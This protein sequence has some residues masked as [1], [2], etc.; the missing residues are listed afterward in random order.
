MKEDSAL[1]GDH[2]ARHRTFAEHG[3]GRAFPEMIGTA[4]V[5][6][7]AQDFEA[8]AGRA[9]RL[10]AWRFPMVGGLKRVGAKASPI[11]LVLLT[12]IMDRNPD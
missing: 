3:L 9:G 2:P 1:S 11:Q 7:L 12:K 8:G 10:W 5:R 6:F 4:V